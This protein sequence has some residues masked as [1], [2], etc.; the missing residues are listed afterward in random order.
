MRINCWLDRDHVF[1]HTARFLS[2][3]WVLH[4]SGE[5]SLGLRVR[6]NRGPTGQASDSIL[7][8]EII[9]D[10]KTRLAMA[11]F[12]DRSDLYSTEALNQCDVYFRRSYYASD[13]PS[14][15]ARKILPLGLN[16]TCRTSGLT[17]AIY[18]ALTPH[19]I[20]SPRVFFRWLR[21]QIRC[22]A[23]VPPLSALE[24]SVSDPLNRAV[25]FQSRLWE[26]SDLDSVAAAEKINQSRVS[27]IRCL[28]ESLGPQFHGGL[29]P[30]PLA[31][32]QYPEL[33]ADQSSRKSAYLK[34]ARS[35][36]V[37][38]YTAGL[39]DSTAW[40]MGEYLTAS[41]CIVAQPPRNSAP[42]DLIPG[43]H[44]LPFTTPE[45]CLAACRKLLD[46]QPL[47]AAMRRANHEYY[48]QE[49]API[50]WIRNRLHEALCLL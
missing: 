44:F 14:E 16:F 5:I 43:T 15:Y 35:Q 18:R 26:E 11:D 27:I 29:V 17:T 47:A 34:F 1:Y 36:L 3:L 49:L 21:R 6:P 38:V 46:D 25:I 23:L 33:L 40:K 12:R 48:R 9:A 22:T 10:G 30:T 2:G 20:S 8:F 50:V 31:R 32:R 7:P 37:G 39:H 41:Q 19:L 4:Q 42:K 45:E 28:R 24:R 13:I